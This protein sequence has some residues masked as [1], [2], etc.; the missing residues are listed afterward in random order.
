MNRTIFLL[1]IVLLFGCSRRDESYFLESG[2]RIKKEIS[3]ELEA[4]KTLSDLFARHET[5]AEYFN[6]LADLAIEARTFQI[7]TK[8]ERPLSAFEQASSERLS[9]ELQRVLAIAGAQAV[10]E[11]CQARAVEKIDSFEKKNKSIA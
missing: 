4:I 6:E 8:K 3:L 1:F 5:L 9:R 7:Q 11:K 2:E 10:I